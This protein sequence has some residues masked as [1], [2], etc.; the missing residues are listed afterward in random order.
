MA[1]DVSEGFKAMAFP[2]N[3]PGMIAG[4]ATVALGSVLI[5]IG[6]AIG[7][8]TLIVASFLVAVLGAVISAL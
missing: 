1:T 8:I 6:F 2:N 5:G 3:L 7:S 4:G